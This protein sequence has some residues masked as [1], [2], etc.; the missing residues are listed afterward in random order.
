MGIPVA[1]LTQKLV[2]RLGETASIG[3]L[4]F[5]A[6]FREFLSYEDVADIP[7]QN[8]HIIMEISVLD[9]DSQVMTPRATVTRENGDEYLIQEEMY[10]Q[11]GVSR[12]ALALKVS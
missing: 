1:S 2:K 3:N 4:E 12:C 10:E 7:I 8:S 9:Y 11:D 6:M 5:P